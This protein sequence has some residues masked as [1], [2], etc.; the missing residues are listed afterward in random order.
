MNLADL[1][2]GVAGIL[3]GA[4]SL[5][6]GVS[7]VHRALNGTGRDGN[8]TERDSGRAYGGRMV[9]RT[10]RNGM[11]VEL[12][13]VK[14]LEDRINAIRTQARKG[15]TDP[16]VITWARKQVSKRCAGKP[17]GW[18]VGEKDTQAE[19]AAIFTGMRRDVRYTSDVLGVDTYVHPK[20]TLE[21]RSG[22]CDDYSSLGCAALMSIGIPCRFKVI[23]T[24]DSQT[25]NHIYLQGGFPKYDPKKWITL[26][27]SVN[28][29]VGWEVPA[30]QVAEAR[31]F[32]VLP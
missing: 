16:T 14:G 7:R 21:Q 28:V 29:P 25:W 5:S 23:R 9:G 17:G 10:T 6:T 13:E 22:D 15:R 12:R 1:S 24:K 32:E 4:R 27:A 26:D 11:T 31:V 20:R 19:I 30:S 3:I 2:F 18:C 8:E